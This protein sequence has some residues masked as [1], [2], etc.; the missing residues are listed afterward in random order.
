MINCKLH[1]LL[2]Y[3]E[4]CFGSARSYVCCLGENKGFKSIKSYKLHY[5]MFCNTTKSKLAFISCFISLQSK[6][7]CQCMTATQSGVK[8]EW[9]LSPRSFKRATCYVI[10]SKTVNNFSA[11][12]YLIDNQNVSVG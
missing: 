5:T 9:F 7:F 6:S 12:N 3:T 4:Q 2:L 11:V 1:H 10:K 8:L